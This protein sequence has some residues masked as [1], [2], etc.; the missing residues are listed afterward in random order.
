[1]SSAT[2]E[3][4]AAAAAAATFAFPTRSEREA[5]LSV[6]RDDFGDVAEKV[7]DA[8]L[9]GDGLRLGDVVPRVQAAAPVVPPSVH[10]IKCALLK[11]L[12]HNVLLVRPAA[13]ASTRGPPAVAYRVNVQEALYRLRFPTF[14][15]QAKKSFG[16][17]VRSSLRMCVGTRVGVADQLGWWRRRC[18]ERW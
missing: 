1:M 10:E 4:V 2:D 12:Q 13:G 6:L 8:L 14:L 5:V 15:E 18:R 17:E 16:L 9:R 11:L 3:Q 7:A